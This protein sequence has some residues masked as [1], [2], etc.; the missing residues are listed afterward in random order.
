MKKLHPL[1]FLG[2]VYALSTMTAQTVPLWVSDRTA[3]FSDRQYV[4]ALGNGN[5][6]Q[7]AKDDALSQIAL[8]FNAR[9]SVER[10]AHLAMTEGKEKHRSIDSDVSVGSEAELPQ[11]LFTAPFKHEKTNEWFVCAYIERSAATDFCTAQLECC[12]FSVQ[13]ALDTLSEKNPTFADMQILSEEKHTVARAEMLLKNLIALSRQSQ[14]A[15]TVK[16]KKLCADMDTLLA[17]ARSGATFHVVVKGDDS[18]MLSAII[19]ETLVSQGMTLSSHGR[20]C[21]L[22]NIAM[23]LSKNNV[24]V[25]ACPNVS[26]SVVDETSG[27]PVY[28]FARQYKKWGHKNEDGARAKALAEV[29]KDIREHFCPV[30]ER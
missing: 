29:E 24:G 27:N 16:L 11:L 15:Y 3:Q 18:E 22:G 1:I 26:L 7:E 6:A 23:A 8:Y 5:T 12:L 28:S 17:K 19:Q 4:S 30:G 20:Y 21:V 13:A 9:I 2:L 10:N 14:N 25:F